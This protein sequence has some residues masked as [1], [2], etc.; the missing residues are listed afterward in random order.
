L[1]GAFWQCPAGCRTPSRLVETAPSGYHIELSAI[2]GCI[3]VDAAEIVCGAGM[4]LSNL[5][6][7]PDGE[8][9]AH[10]ISLLAHE[11][12]SMADKANLGFLA[13]LLAMVEDEA[14]ASARKQAEDNVGS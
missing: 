3:Q 9:T 1:R 13:Y 5:P 6:L 4:V 8:H 11:L 7:Q 2:N 14:T 12:R 10:Y